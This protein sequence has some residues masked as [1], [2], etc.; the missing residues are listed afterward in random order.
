M[1][2]II[3]AVGAGGKTTYLKKRAV[4]YLRQ[5]KSVVI[6]TSTHIWPPRDELLFQKTVMRNEDDSVFAD[7]WFGMGE[8]PDYCGHLQESGKLSALNDDELERLCGE[9]DVVL[10]EGDGSHCMP[11]KIPGENEPVIPFLTDEIVVVMGAHAIGRRLDVV[12]H[13]Y[14]L[15]ESLPA[16]ENCQDGTP[17]EFHHSGESPSENPESSHQSRKSSPENPESFHQSRKSPSANPEDYIRSRVNSVDIKGETLQGYVTEQMLA[18]IAERF[19]IDKLQSEYP[20]AKVSYVLSH[21]PKPGGRIVA[22]IMASGFGRRYGR[23]K[24]LDVYRG[25]PLYRHALEHITG[26]L[27]RENTVVV[28]QYEQIADEVGSMGTAAVMNTKALEG[29]SASIRIGTQWAMKK[30][31][32]AVMFFAADMP[33][34]PSQEIRLYADQFLGSQKPY[35]CMVFGPEHICSNP[36]AFRLDTG[37]QKLMSL[38]GDKGAMRIMK[39]EPWNIY[40]YQIAPECCEDVDLPPM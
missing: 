8:K 21:M 32:D 37:A 7:A 10:V 20:R 16:G 9:Y 3:T 24:L 6:T 2:Y 19:Y 30:G 27:G 17:E 34:L 18:D 29:I 39:Q 13:R 31:A 22:V 12:C 23:N 35:G 1:G 4:E 5:G 38:T 28:T 33:D 36:G 26:A 11:V 25:K 15:L 14:A 40:Y